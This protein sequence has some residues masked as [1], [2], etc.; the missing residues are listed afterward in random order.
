MN[1]VV[2]VIFDSAYLSTAM[3]TSIPCFK[4]VT[5]EQFLRVWYITHS[6][7]NHFT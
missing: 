5:K 1:F 4:T 6:T 3:R 7:N 2:L